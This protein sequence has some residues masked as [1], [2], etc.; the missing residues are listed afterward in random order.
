MTPSP[1]THPPHHGPDE[2]FGNNRLT[3]TSTSL[4]F[5]SPAAC[6]VRRRTLGTDFVSPL[7]SSRF[8]SKASQNCERPGG[9]SARADKR[10]G[11]AGHLGPFPP[12]RLRDPQADQCPRPQP[13]FDV[14]ASRA[15]SPRVL[16]PHLESRSPE[17]RHPPSRAPTA[18]VSPK[19]PTAAR[20]QLGPGGGVLARRRSPRAHA[21]YGTS[22]ANR[23]PSRDPRPTPAPQARSLRSRLT[24]PGTVAREGRNWNE[25]EGGMASLSLIACE[26]GRP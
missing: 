15:P 22:P 14:S 26:S 17:R 18:R 1:D 25:P 8:H 23:L 21:E 6:S 9:R 2:I 12:L 11:A 24:Q 3:S 7:S 20:R 16:E 13:T 19:P 5:A 4:P 10:L